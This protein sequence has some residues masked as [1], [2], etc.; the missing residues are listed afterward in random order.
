MTLIEVVLYLALFAIMFLSVMEFAMATAEQN[1]NALGRSEV[2]KNIMFATE[3]LEEQFRT[4][5]SI[6]VANTVF[7]TDSGTLQ[8]VTSG[9]V[10]QYHVVSGTLIFTDSTGDIEMTGPSTAVERFYLEE[11]RDGSNQMV[12]VRITLMVR[13]VGENISD[14]ITTSYIL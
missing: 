10:V 6:D 5:S 14:Q 12:G 11:I 2:Q 13:Y 9:G 1:R 3:H 8:L 4:V 7:Y